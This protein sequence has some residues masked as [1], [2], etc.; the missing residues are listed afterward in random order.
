MVIDA[1]IGVY[2]PC[3]DSYPDVVTFQIARR[4]RSE[5]YPQAKANGRRQHRCQGDPELKKLLAGILLA[6]LLVS[7]APAQEKTYDVPGQFSFQYSDGW[8]KGHRK[9]GTEGEMD[10]LVS[11]A[12][13][14]ASFHPV[15]AHA[16]FAFDSWVRRT[17]N[18]A[19]PERA[20]ASKT[21]F[22]TASG[23]K[24]FKLV[25]N[26]KA[27][28]GQQ[29]TSYNYMFSGKGSSQLLLSGMVDAASASKFEPAFDGFAK[30][31]VIDKGK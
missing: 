27:P 20:L 31:L 19:T 9:G 1:A 28:G 18:Q 16:D 13:S 4:A 12:D 2:N 15:V 24:G 21:E 10:W 8:N 3:W 14:T 26:I 5:R 17:I 29:L 23:V 11:A 25:W 6:L 30:S 7:F 22:A